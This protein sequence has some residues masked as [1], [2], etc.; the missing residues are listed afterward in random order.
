MGL[1]NEC[2]LDE[3]VLREFVQD[4]FLNQDIFL[5]SM[6]MGGWK[7][8]NLIFM[9]ER[10]QN[11]NYNSES[12]KD[13]YINDN[14]INVLVCVCDVSHFIEFTSIVRINIKSKIE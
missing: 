2:G 8:L 3:C 7:L 11:E 10:E 1:R 9:D 13:R 6:L 4:F 14:Y 5:T 12:E